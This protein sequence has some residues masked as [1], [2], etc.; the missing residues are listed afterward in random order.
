M[1]AGSRPTGVRTENR[2]P[3][4]GSWSRTVNPQLSAMARKGVVGGL[5][6]HGD[7]IADGVPSHRVGERLQADQQLGQR[8]GRAARFGDGDEVGACEVD[9]AEEV[10]ERVRVDVVEEMQAGRIP[11][12]TETAVRKR[13]QGLAAEGRA[14]GAQH[15]D[16]VR[17]FA[18][19]FGPGLDH[20]D[21]VPVAGQAEQRQGAVAVRAPQCVETGSGP[22][23]HRV[24]VG[25]VEAG[26]A[27]AA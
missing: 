6:D 10:V 3:M 20:R 18:V 27:E 12:R 15:D 1:V 14:A 11:A 13:V 5:R 22:L 8:L 19:V 2:P 25:A 26:G 7:V 17:V 24:E 16:G 4:P 9:R 23:E 21:V